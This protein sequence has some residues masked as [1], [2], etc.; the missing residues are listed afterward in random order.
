VTLSG[1]RE[2]PSPGDPDGSGLAVLSVEGSTIYY[3][4]W[5]KTMEAPI[6]S[7]LHQARSGKVGSA[8]IPFDAPFTSAGADTFISVGSTNASSDILDAVLSDPGD[9]YVNVENSSFPDGAVRGQLLGDGPSPFAFTTE[10]AGSEGGF[11]ATYRGHGTAS[12][13]V[14]GTN[15]HYY[16]RTDLTDV[17]G[18]VINQS[19]YELGQVLWNGTVTDPRTFVFAG[20]VSIRSDVAEDILNHPDRHFVEA[21]DLGCS[22]SFRGRLTLTETDLTLPV[23]AHNPGRGTSFFRTDVRLQSLGDVDTVVWAE[24]YPTNS[25]GLEGP[26]GVISID[27]AAGSV[28]V[29]DDVVESLFEASDRGAVRFLSASPFYAVANTYN[30]QRASG[31]GTYGQFVEALGPERAYSA[32]SMLL[33]SHHERATGIDHRLNL[34]YFNPSPVATSVTF[35]VRRPSGALLASRIVT[36]PPYSNGIESY[37]RIAGQEG[38]A[39]QDNFFITYSS[40]GPVYLFSSLVDNVTDDGLYQAALPIPSALVKSP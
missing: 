2:A 18:I 4:I 26:A 11:S 28:V 32:G 29:L 17:V 19:P 8:V 12:I 30:D 9:F 21:F 16:V 1:S 20:N 5:V 10:L 24:W 7:H 34:G 37:W 36:F 31:S 3:Y 14:D 39:E 25:A 6:A 40:D 15:I 22:C 27:V 38:P 33:G 23:A 35:N 13:V